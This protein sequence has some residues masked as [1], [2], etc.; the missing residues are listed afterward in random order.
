MIASG[1]EAAAIVAEDGLTQ[2]SDSGSLEKILEKI[3]AANPSQTEEYKAGKDKLL[4]FF[5]GLAMKQTKGQA[6]P[7]VL[8]QL[9]KKMLGR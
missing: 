4:G 3:F 9:I 5:V 2:V 8:N 1:Q 6:N 7:A